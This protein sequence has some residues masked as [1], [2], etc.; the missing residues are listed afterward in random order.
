MEVKRKQA[1]NTAGNPH[2]FFSLQQV[3]F[4]ILK[5]LG[6]KKEHRFYVCVCVRTCVSVCVCQHDQDQMTQFDLTQP[7][8]IKAAFRPGGPETQRHFCW[9]TE[10]VFPPEAE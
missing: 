7:G 5:N 3:C 1:N 2:P 6:E 4:F 8:L 9:S 10:G